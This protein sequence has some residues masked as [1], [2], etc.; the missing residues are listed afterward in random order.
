[1]EIEKGLEIIELKFEEDVRNPEV[2]R[3]SYTIRFWSMK[4]L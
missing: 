4:E 3:C 2:E 1:M